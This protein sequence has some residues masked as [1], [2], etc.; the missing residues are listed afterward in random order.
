MQKLQKLIFE[1]AQAALV[2]WKNV[3]DLRVWYV[4]LSPTAWKTIIFNPKSRVVL[5]TGPIK[6]TPEACLSA[7]KNQLN[8]VVRKTS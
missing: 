2:R 5:I 1:V 8:A 7:V 4:M 3:P 6:T